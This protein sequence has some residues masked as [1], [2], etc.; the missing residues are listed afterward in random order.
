[1]YVGVD[2]KSGHGIG[3]GDTSKGIGSGEG[4]GGCGDGRGGGCFRVPETIANVFESTVVQRVANRGGDGTGR[5]R[6]NGTRAV[7]IVIVGGIIVFSS[8][9]GTIGLSDRVGI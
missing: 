5:V 7:R 9:R 1:M 4:S 8:S 2:V 6:L 3:R